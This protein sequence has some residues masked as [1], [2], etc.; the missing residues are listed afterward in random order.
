MSG[1]YA[2][3]DFFMINTLA[4]T[5]G[6]RCNFNCAHCIAGDKREMGLT[7][8]EIS[9]AVAAVREH[10]IKHVL[11][12]GGE[13]TLYLD[14]MRDI[15][16]RLSGLGVEY[17]MTTN[18]H[19]ASTIEAAQEIL[20]SIPEL[21]VVNISCDKQH[22]KFL[23]ESH[24]RNLYAACKKMGI[25]FRAILSLS[26]PMDLVLLKKLKALGDFPVLPQKMLPMGS[27]KKNQLGYSHP[28]FDEGVWR[29]ICPNRGIIVYMCGQGFTTCCAAPAFYSKSG[30]IVHPTLGG[31]M[32]SEFY[33]LV[34]NFNLGGIAER[35]GLTGIE[36][37]PEDS[38]PCVLCEKLFKRKYGDDL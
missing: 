25:A 35:L 24:M 4:I 31:H 32:A 12:I 2:A 23:P 28:S 9:L 5:L 38:S 13:P 22:E 36:T 30:R 15:I 33:G 27:A 19:F 11:F 34:S 37:A 29:K 20:S 21:A 16:S 10:R 17:R 6:Y 18:G 7:A 1:A 3:P 26:S 8:A 14:E